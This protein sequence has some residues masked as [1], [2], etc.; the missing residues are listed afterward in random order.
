[1]EF[2]MFTRCQDQP[3]AVLPSLVVVRKATDLVEW[4]MTPTKAEEGHFQKVATDMQGW[5]AWWKIL[6]CNQDCRNH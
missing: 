2:R 1:M 3:R 6:H 4:D 5:G